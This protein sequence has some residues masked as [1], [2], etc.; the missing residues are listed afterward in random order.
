MNQNRYFSITID[1]SFFIIINFNFDNR[2]HLSIVLRNGNTYVL[3]VL[4]V[5]FLILNVFVL[6]ITILIMPGNKCQYLNCLKTTVQFPNLSMFRFPKDEVR[7]EVWVL[8]CGVF[9]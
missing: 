1:S 9:N 6:Q 2:L 7:S 8:N 3:I 4:N 5:I